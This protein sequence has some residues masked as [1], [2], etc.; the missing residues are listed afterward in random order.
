MASPEEN[1][2]VIYNEEGEYLIQL[3]DHA[4]ELDGKEAEQL[5]FDL[6]AAM[7]ATY[8]RKQAES[9]LP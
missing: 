3:G 6:A 4:V 1:I 9:E 2:K 5:L 8:Y 7:K